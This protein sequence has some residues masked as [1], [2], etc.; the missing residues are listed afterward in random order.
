MELKQSPKESVYYVY[1]EKSLGW[2]CRKHNISKKV[3]K[4]KENEK[5]WS[6]R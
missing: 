6:N 4:G 5:V 3:G 2:A 1:L